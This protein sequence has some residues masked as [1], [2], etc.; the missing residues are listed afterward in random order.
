MRR[1]WASQKLVGA[2]PP[3]ATI[4]EPL[5]NMA[6][7]YDFDKDGDPDILGTEGVGAAKNTN[8]VLARNDGKGRKAKTFGGLRLRLIPRTCG[9]RATSDY[10]TKYDDE[11]V[12]PVSRYGFSSCQISIPEKLATPPELVMLMTP[13]A[14]VVTHGPS[15][16]H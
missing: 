13:L 11:L 5:R 7:V 15:R 16:C 6:I 8:F 12:S 14:T 2:S 4:G 1:E 9:T 3:Q 10:V